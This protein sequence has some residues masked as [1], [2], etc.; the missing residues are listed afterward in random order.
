MSSGPRSS[1]SRDGIDGGLRCLDGL[2][3]IEEGADDGGVE[4]G[5]AGGDDGGGGGVR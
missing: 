2:A 4:Q 1:L 3:D 5:Q